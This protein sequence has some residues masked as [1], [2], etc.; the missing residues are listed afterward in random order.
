MTDREGLILQGCGGDPREWVNGINKLLTEAGILLDGDKFTDISAFQNNGCT[1]LLFDMEN[2]NLDTGKLALWRL[3]T[4]STFGGTWLSDY[5]TNQLGVNP[6]EKQEPLQR[7]LQERT[8]P[9]AA[10]IG[11]DGNIFN[12]LGIARNALCQANLRDEAK[13]MT[14]RVL[15]SGGYDNA[16]AIIAEYVEPVEIGERG[17]FEMMM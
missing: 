17:G 13:E 7:P 10:I 1:N 15:S 16:L 5:R 4:H 6:D 3:R 11:A 9:E 2:V 14:E 8:K 12:I